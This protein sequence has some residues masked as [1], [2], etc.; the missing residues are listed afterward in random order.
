MEAN[1][2]LFEGQVPMVIQQ[3]DAGHQLSLA[4][5]H[6][7]MA[8]LHHHHHNN[9]VGLAGAQTF[10]MITVRMDLAKVHTPQPRRILHV[11]LTD[12]ADPFFFYSLYLFER[13]LIYLL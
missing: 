13:I 11:Q 6:S 5:H 2:T 1:E 9:Q 8:G 3:G 4:G 7:S 10:T 12:E